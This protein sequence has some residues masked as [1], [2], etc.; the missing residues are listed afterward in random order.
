MNQALLFDPGTA[1]APTLR[2]LSAQRRV[3]VA[4][5]PSLWEVFPN[6]FARSV[7]FCVKEYER[8]RR[9][10]NDELGQLV[11]DQATRAVRSLC[12]R[13]NPEARDELISASIQGVLKRAKKW[14]PG[15][16]KTIEV[17]VN[18]AAYQAVKDTLRKRKAS[19]NALDHASDVE[20][21]DFEDAPR[22]PLS[23]LDLVTERIAA[24]FP[25]CDAMALTRSWLGRFALRARRRLSRGRSLKSP[26]IQLLCL[27]RCAFRELLGQQNLCPLARRDALAA[28]IIGVELFEHADWG[29]IERC[30]TQIKND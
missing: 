26:E 30:M 15:G 3:K 24:A 10:S 17:Y 12:P 13:L 29:Q 23:G 2:V 11:L 6:A 20:D 27:A 4:A 16:P 14:K 7:R 8:N 1:E 5:P 22:A 19:R 9:R 21:I 25:D 18:Q 28:E